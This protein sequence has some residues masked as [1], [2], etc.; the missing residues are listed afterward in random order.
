MSA[1]RQQVERDNQ[2]T[3]LNAEEFGASYTINGRP[4]VAVLDDEFLDARMP[5]DALG[6]HAATKTLFVRIADFG[7]KPLPGAEIT[8][9]AGRDNRYRVVHVD[10]NFGMYYIHLA[11]WS[12]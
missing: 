1:F 11:R 10:D 6:V 8:L 4:M 9:G 12:Q 7:A 5:T 2:A 3:M